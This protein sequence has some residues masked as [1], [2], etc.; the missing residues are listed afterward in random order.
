[1]TTDTPV[2][3]PILEAKNITKRF[4]HP[5]PLE[6]LKGIDLAIYPGKSMAIVGKSGEGKTTLLH[7]LGTIDDSSTGKLFIAGKEATSSE[8]DA[9]RNQHI[10]FIF[11]SFHLLADTCVLDNLLMPVKIARKSTSKGSFHYNKAIELLEMVGLADRI[12]FSSNKLSGGEKQRVAIA[13]AFMNDPEIILADEPT[14]NLDHETAHDIQE[15]LLNAV[16]KAGKAL[17]LVT[18]NLQLATL[19]DACYE[20]EGGYLKKSS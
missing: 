10:G 1:M 16:Q 5:S 18:H 8:K 6:I 11:Q 4:P 19:L 3:S 17:V 12:H 14:G 7:I 2:P 13:R 20:L 9:I 15:L